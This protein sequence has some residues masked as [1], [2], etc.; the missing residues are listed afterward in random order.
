MLSGTRSQEKKRREDT[1]ATK[2][3][4]SRSIIFA[5]L[6]LIVKGLNQHY[7]QQF[8][9]I[10]RQMIEMTMQMKHINANVKNINTSTKPRTTD[11]NEFDD[12]RC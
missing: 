7:E 10:M 3:L 9:Q 11:E 6:K 8:D 2:E 12:R 5:N 4:S 1:I